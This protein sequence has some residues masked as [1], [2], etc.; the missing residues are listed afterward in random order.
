MARTPKGPKQVTT[1]NHE[2]D[3]RRNIPTAELADLAAMQEERDPL[4]PAVYPRAR[5]LAQG[6]STVLALSSSSIRQMH[7]SLCRAATTK[8]KLPST[9]A[10]VPTT[11]TLRQNPSLSFQRRRVS[12]LADQVKAVLMLNGGTSFNVGS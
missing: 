8:R 10:G 3:V 4:A 2:A 6:P 9:R 7:G 1:L 5:P 12:N 11:E